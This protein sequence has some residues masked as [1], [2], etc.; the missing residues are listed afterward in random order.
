MPIYKRL[1]WEYLEQ[2]LDAH[3]MP[4]FGAIFYVVWRKVLLAIFRERRQTKTNP[5]CHQTN[6]EINRV[7][8]AFLEK[9]RAE[10]TSKKRWSTKRSSREEKRSKMASTWVHVPPYNKPY[11]HPQIPHRC[12]FLLLALAPRQ[13]RYSW[14]FSL[15]HPRQLVL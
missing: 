12:S 3:K 6:L 4:D 5:S 7:N 13:Q 1:R 10:N 14:A 11:I 8:T 15:S 9:K 2:I